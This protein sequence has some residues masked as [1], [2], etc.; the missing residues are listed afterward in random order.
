MDKKH[1]SSPV[2]IPFILVPRIKIFQLSEDADIIHANWTLSAFSAWVGKLLN[3]KPIKIKIQGRDMV[4]AAK[5]PVIKPLT[6]NTLNKCDKIAALSQVISKEI[7]SLG[8]PLKKIKI[9]SKGVNTTKM[10]MGEDNRDLIMLFVG[11]LI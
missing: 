9:I 11:S 3:W 7:L 4:K 1:F 5:L 8:I 10:L 6:K 2:V